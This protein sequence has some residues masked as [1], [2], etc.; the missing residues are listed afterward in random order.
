[1]TRLTLIVVVL[2]ASLFA[3]FNVVNAAPTVDPIDGIL[4]NVSLDRENG[5]YTADLTVDSVTSS[6]Y[7]EFTEEMTP[8]FDLVDGHVDVY[9]ETYLDNDGTISQGNRYYRFW[10]F[11]TP[12]FGVIVAISGQHGDAEYDRFAAAHPMCTVLVVID[13]V[14]D[15][16]S[17]YIYT[18][19]SCNLTQA[20][21]DNLPEQYKGILAITPRYDT[22][23]PVVMN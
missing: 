10:N 13:N 2:F 15:E 1:M 8:S 18:K 5:I 9:T 7:L 20:E 11:Q 17:P 21:I 3:S 4:K 22:Y 19:V 12:T 23:V 14:D 6:V 16:L